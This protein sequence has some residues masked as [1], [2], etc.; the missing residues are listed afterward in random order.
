MILSVSFGRDWRYGESSNEISTLISEVTEQLEPEG[1][2]GGSYSPGQDAWFCLSEQRHCDENQVADNFLRVAV[3]R[4]TGYGGIVWG[5]TESSPRT[6]GI[7]DSVWISNN[8]EPPNFDP[9]VVSD[10]GVPLFHDPCS[11]LPISQVR[12]AVE[13]F[14]RTGTGDRPECIGWVPGHASGR[15][16]DKESVVELVQNDNP[17]G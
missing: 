15:R 17:F 9:R 11:T 5:V 13:E 3:N 10:P 14:C 1:L 8:P 2:V 7:Y 12:A 6:G 16:L 4:S